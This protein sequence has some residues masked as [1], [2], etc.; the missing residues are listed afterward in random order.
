MQ[1]ILIK[2][3]SIII[4]NSNS[5]GCTS[6]T[7]TGFTKPIT[8]KKFHATSILNYRPDIDG[9]R[10]LAILAVLLF[11]FFPETF[12]GGFIGVDIFF[13]ISGFLITSI[14]AKTIK[15]GEFSFKD[16]YFRRIRRIFPGLIAILL[17]TLFIGYFF[18]FTHE[19]LAFSRWL[20][21]ATV[22]TSNFLYAAEYGYFDIEAELKPLNHLWSLA[23]E[24]QFYLFWPFI[25]WACY[26]LNIKPILIIG[27]AFLFSVIFCL[28]P[29]AGDSQR[30]FYSTINRVWELMA[31]SLIAYFYFEKNEGVYALIK[32]FCIKNSNLL[33]NLGIILIASS[34]LLISK[35]T[36]YPGL[37]TAIPIIGAIFL[38]ISG[39]NSFLGQK[40]LS[41]RIFVF[42]G[43]ISYP[44]Y[45][46]HWP[47]LAF[48][49]I[50][51]GNHLSIIFRL[52]LLTYSVVLA[53]LTWILI[54]KKF[55]KTSPIALVCIM[56]CI[57]IFANLIHYF[58]GLP[59]RLVNTPISNSLFNDE[60]FDAARHQNNSCQ[61]LGIE[62]P[63]EEVCIT[64]SSSPEYLIIGDSQAMA[65]YSAVLSGN[66]SKKAILIAGHACML[67]PNLNF[68]PNFK[69]PYGNRCDQIA[70]HALK[71]SQQISSIKNVI[72][73]NFIDSLSKN[74]SSKYLFNGRVL[75]EYDAFILGE[76][77]AINSLLKSKNVFLTVS[78]HELPLYPTQ[79]I[80]RF[81]INKNG[82]EKCDSEEDE[83]LKRRKQYFTAINLLK[84][85]YP[86]LVIVNFNNAICNKNQCKFYDSDGSLYHD[87]GHLS[88]YGA[89]KMWE[90]IK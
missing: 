42:I 46:W 59:K 6:V 32:N 37:P 30:L 80:N 21:S 63:E 57:Y 26:K 34:L 74:E 62:V 8:M 84:I 72:I 82:L 53:Y 68:E 5:N 48:A 38:I 77:S 86:D 88:T 64:N 47:L 75:S 17:T 67:Y 56:V 66:V 65:L 29:S 43:L 78:I 50:F 69:S 60:F 87:R 44:L 51:Y 55:R 1:F 81:F 45:L 3:T 19:Y 4:C 52:M 12:R 24:E 27:F 89:I 20:E 10:A 49:K 39:E 61:E 36:R 14:I 79:C 16:F 7:D 58:D 11:H 73:V 18:L 15:D 28:Y 35:D 85:K 13:V 76:D 25:I 22:F 70:K 23:V 40:I 9:L 71:I 83:L 33:A 31:G 90:L 54:E 41:S 2:V